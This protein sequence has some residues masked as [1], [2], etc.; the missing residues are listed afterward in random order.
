MQVNTVGEEMVPREKAVRREEQL[1]GIM[2]GSRSEKARVKELEREVE[3]TRKEV[4]ELLRDRMIR[5]GRWRKRR[6]GFM[7]RED[8][9]ERSIEQWLIM[10]CRSFR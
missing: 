10:P 4:G 5:G 6:G 7:E 3:K 1:R 8:I 2:E 9:E